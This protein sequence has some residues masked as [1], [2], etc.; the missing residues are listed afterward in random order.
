MAFRGIDTAQIGAGG[1][2]FVGMCQAVPVDTMS[3]ADITEPTIAVN[4]Y[5]RLAITRDSIGWPTEGTVNNEPFIEAL[6]RVFVPSGGAFD[7]QTTRL[8]LTPEV[9]ALAGELW[10]LSEAFSALPKT[11]DLSTPLGERTFRYRIHTR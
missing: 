10:A 5:A 3:L 11:F 2:F 9:S 8:F 6:D 7:Q 4:G 1:D